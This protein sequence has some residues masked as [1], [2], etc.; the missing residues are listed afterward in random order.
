MEIRK[1]KRK[2]ESKGGK[3][4]FFCILFC[5][6]EAN[7]QKMHFLTNIHPVSQLNL[8]ELKGLGEEE[9]E[10]I[11]EYCNTSCNNKEQRF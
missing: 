10:L 1:G 8:A 6:T 11:C 5:S 4:Y 7:F 3:K 9:T 2:K